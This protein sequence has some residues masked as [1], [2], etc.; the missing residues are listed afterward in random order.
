M[1]AG[2]LSIFASLMLLSGTVAQAEPGV[3]DKE[4]ILGSHIA[5]SGKFAD[6]G[7]VAQVLRVFFDDINEKG[8]VH[9]RKIKYINVDGKGTAPG[10]LEATKRLVE[11]E[12]VFAMIAG[13]TPVQNVVFKYL[14]EKGVPDVMN[15]SG[16]RQTL[17]P[18]ERTRFPGNPSSF[19]D[20][21]TGSQALVK[22]FPGKKYCY[23][24]QANEQGAQYREGSQKAIEEHNKANPSGAITI[25]PNE[26]VDRLAMNSN[27]EV[28]KLKKA[29]CEVVVS[30]M[31]GS[32]LAQAVNFGF[33]RQFKPIWMTHHT[34]VA[35]WIVPFLREDIRGSVFAA[36][37]I[38]RDITLDP[39]KTK[40]WAEIE[41]Y[42]K[43]LGFTDPGQVAL[44]VYQGGVV[45][46]ALKRA[47]K[48]V[49]REKFIKAM[50]SLNGY[51]CDMCLS[52]LEYSDKNHWPFSKQYLVT[53]ANGS[54]TLAK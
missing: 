29:G 48:D 15:T 47:G 26:D 31:F 22:K 24:S 12:N 46:E 37:H 9:G 13:L 36:A 8:G 43:K 52:P 30:T 49:T 50:E 35:A 6:S 42:K 40:V 21:Y 25:G 39:S 2:A 51:K 7:R 16:S 19:T 5:E 1:K 17:E 53:I 33:D 11:R 38:L 27:V 23:L 34:N 3:S 4:I 20:G 54:W 10:I 32:A 18:F 44:A 41:K 14:A 45:V 28:L